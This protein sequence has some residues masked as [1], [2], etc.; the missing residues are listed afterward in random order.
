[1]RPRAYNP[2]LLTAYYVQES[3]PA[4]TY[5][6]RFHPRRRWRFDLAWPE[7]KVA[8]E[9]DGGTWARAPG[10]TWGAG[11]AADRE[12]QN[13]AV[14]LGWRVLRCTPQEVY[15]LDMLNMLRELILGFY[16]RHGAD[17]LHDQ[18]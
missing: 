7:H 16:R 12:K 15:S 17:D 1:M 11:I 9:V 10:H 18:A 2:T 5:E 14:L 8:L 13:A 6:H 3:L 4:P